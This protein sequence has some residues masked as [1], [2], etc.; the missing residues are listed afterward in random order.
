MTQRSARLPEQDRPISRNNARLNGRHALYRIDGSAVHDQRMTD[1][2]LRVR[3]SAGLCGSCRHAV[4]RPTRR[5]TVYLRC[6]L[7]GTDGARYVKYPQLP[8]VRCDGYRPEPDHH[9]VTGTAAASGER[10]DT[11]GWGA[12]G[13]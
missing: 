4:V 1:P 10:P 9:G 2:L 13:I 6:A 11:P 12:A 3:Q 7:A 5:G 8:V